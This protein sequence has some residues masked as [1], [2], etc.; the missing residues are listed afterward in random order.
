MKL[1]LRISLVLAAV[2]AVV[3]LAFEVATLMRESDLL[4]ADLRRDARLVAH[5]LATAAAHAPA[6]RDPADTLAHLLAD[7]AA[8][9]DELDIAWVPIEEDLRA[10]VGPAGHARLERGEVVLAEAQ[11]PDGA[12]ILAWAPVRDAE[13]RLLG[14]VQVAEPLAVRD[15]FIARGLGTAVLA[16][17]GVALL[18]GGAALVFGRVLVGSRVDRLVEKTRQVAR[19]DLDKPV[20]LAGGD[21]LAALGAALERMSADLARLQRTAR[22]EGEARLTAER[23]LAHADRLRTVGELAAG[24]AHE[25]GTPLNVITGRAQLIARRAEDERTRADATV[26]RDQ[27]ARIGRIVRAMMDFS[28]A[29]TPA[30]TRFDLADLVERSMELL[31]G[32]ARKANVSLRLHAPAEGVPIVADPEQLTHVVTNLVLNA[33]HASPDGGFVHVRVEPA[34]AG[35][36]AL[37]VEDEGPG[38]PEADRDRVFEPFFTTKAPGDGTGLGLSIVRRIVSDHGGR[39]T[40]HTAPGGGAAFQVALPPRERA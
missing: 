19:G 28:R 5:T 1:T 27:V 8:A 10:L 22:E 40:I 4:E 34:R 9:E 14:L 30:P 31:A 36:A 3:L 17:V 32:P 39:I 37:V 16:V 18:T 26:V 15:Q 29:S 7:V 24:V 25:L 35:G 38:V 6:G 21:E 13:G 23:A 20:G 12:A 11:R 33:V 2:M